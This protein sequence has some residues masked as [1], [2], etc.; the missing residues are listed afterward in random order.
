[1]RF[2]L[3][4]G[5][6]LA[7]SVSTSPMPVDAL[8]VRAPNI[9]ATDAP[10]G[11]GDFNIIVAGQGQNPLA[12][13]ACYVSAVS[14][15]AMQASQDFHDQLRWP[16]T[17]FTD[18]RYPDLTIL[19][20]GA[21][22]SDRIPRRYV[23]W[24]MARLMNHLVSG[25]DFRDSF[26]LLRFQGSVVGSIYIG[27]PPQRVAQSGTADKPLV[28]LEQSVVDQ[29]ND[30]T[31][32]S[33]SAD[34]LSWRYQFYGRPLTMPDIFMGA[35]GAL[36]EAAQPASDEKLQSFTGFFQPYM[37]IYHWVSTRTGPSSFTY[38]MLIR[39]I[40]ASAMYAFDQM[41]FHQLRVRVFNGSQEIGGGGYVTI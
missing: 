32:T 17:A 22:A 13:K 29:T 11:P 9:S 26:F 1:M 16:W 34:V 27:P 38:G 21:H 20:A 15:L 10:W 6:L 41:D 25:N 24:G 30:T 12:R 2:L 37:A 35:I 4:V 33:I 39:S 40:E 23:L 3:F 5:S 18:A 31:A 19:V 14:M 28:V 8:S 36:I 7:S